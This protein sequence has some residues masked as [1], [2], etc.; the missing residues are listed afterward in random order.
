M[1]R[2]GKGREGKGREGRNGGRECYER[3]KEE[4]TEE[5]TEAKNLHVRHI[6]KKGT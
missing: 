6:R 4:G 2:D 3:E 5:G 1:G